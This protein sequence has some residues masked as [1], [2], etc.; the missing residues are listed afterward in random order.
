MILRLFTFG[1]AALMRSLG[2][3]R[4]TLAGPGVELVVNEL[5]PRDGEPWV[6]L[7][8]MGS[9]SASWALVARRLRS[10]CRV[11]IPE[12][13]ALGGTRSTHQSLNVQEGVEAVATMITSRLGGRPATVAGISLGGW[14]A[15]RLALARPELVDRLL[16]VNCAGYRDQDWARI[17][18]LVRIDDLEGVDRLQRALFHRRPLPLRL[19]RRGL[20]AAYRSPSVRHV[21]DSLRVE[22]SFDAEDLRRLEL[23]VG[24]IWA[25]GDGMFE[26]SVA[27]AM[28]AA[29]PSGRLEIVPEC[30]HGIQWERPRALIDATLRFRRDTAAA[31]DP[32]AGAP[33]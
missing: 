24:L 1:T 23:P 13:S 6:L 14:I 19:T 26:P 32:A 2:A 8:G 33:L 4:T 9:T 12:L 5:G 21:L 22:D 11:L 3:R 15:T 29:L 20:L 18:R 25:D 10:N 7:H 16:L 17:E 28:H 27:R 31:G 30:G